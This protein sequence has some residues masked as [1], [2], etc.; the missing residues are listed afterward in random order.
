M[1]KCSEFSRTSLEGA[2]KL[3]TNSPTDEVLRVFSHKCQVLH[4]VIV[5]IAHI[6]LVVV[7]ALNIVDKNVDL[8]VFGWGKFQDIATKWGGV[9]VVAEVGLQVVG[10][11]AES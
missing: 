1:A 9:N 2:I 5:E 8:F 7:Q 11:M 6:S 3:E 4:D 10:V